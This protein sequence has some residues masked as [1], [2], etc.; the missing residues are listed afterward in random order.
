MLFLVELDRVNPG[1]VM[2][3]EAGR[4]FIENVIFP[5]LARSEQLV[6]QKGILGG[7]A[8]LGRVG[9][10]FIMEADSAQQVDRMIES[11]PVW[12]V[13]DTRVT[14]LVTFAE[15]RQALQQ[16]LETLAATPS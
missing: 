1:T 14:P 10:R 3:P 9:L 4:A 15:R 5:T 6:A 16:L 8:V 7:G 13:A 12:T 11:L 2:T